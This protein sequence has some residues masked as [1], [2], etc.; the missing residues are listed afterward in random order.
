MRTINKFYYLNVMDDVRK[1]ANLGIRANDEGVIVVLDTMAIEVC[2]EAARELYG[3]T[4][5]FFVYEIDG[6]GIT[7]EIKPMMQEGKPV[8]HVWQILQSSFDR[9]FT[10]TMASY[11]VD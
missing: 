6:Q 7:G 8:V 2:Q 3:I 5:P 11:R 1:L 10:R 4:E 9:K